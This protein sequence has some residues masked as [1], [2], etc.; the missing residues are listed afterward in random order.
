MSASNNHSKLREREATAPP[1][2]LSMSPHASGAA[3]QSHAESS[4]HHK[5]GTVALALN[6]GSALQ[7][8]DSLL[9]RS[10]YGQ[11]AARLR[12]VQL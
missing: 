8:C 12:H 11:N 2:P 9:F 5:P 4:K 3:A 10:C 7:G 1:S 6:V